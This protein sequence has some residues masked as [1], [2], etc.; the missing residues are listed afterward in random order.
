MRIIAMPRTMSSEATRAGGRAVSV[1][2]EGGSY[3]V[4]AVADLTAPVD[5]VVTP[6]GMG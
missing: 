5:M 2:L 6:L 4:V 1:V 3:G